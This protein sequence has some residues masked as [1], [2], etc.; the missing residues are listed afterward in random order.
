MIG[1]GSDTCCTEC[2]YAKDDSEL[3]SSIKLN[4]RSL[5]LND[6]SLMDYNGVGC[7]SRGLYTDCMVV[8]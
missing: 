2:Y 1:S 7:N 5:E 3:Q 6:H 8:T 4:D